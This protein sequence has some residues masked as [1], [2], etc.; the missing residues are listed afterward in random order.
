[1]KTRRFCLTIAT[2]LLIILGHSLMARTAAASF[3]TT[4]MVPKADAA[5][6]FR[7][8]IGAF[9]GVV[10][11]WTMF[12]LCVVYFVRREMKKMLREA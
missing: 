7:I 2:F 11:G 6:A 8:A 9:T 5:V 3:E 4:Q 10:L 1:M 12:S